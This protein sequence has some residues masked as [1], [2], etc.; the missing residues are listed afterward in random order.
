MKELERER[1]KVKVKEH[2]TVLLKVT[3][4][5]ISKIRDKTP[6]EGVALSGH[7]RAQVLGYQGSIF[8]NV[9]NPSSFSVPL[10]QN[11]NKTITNS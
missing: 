6:G 5:L 3:V 11:K 1:V 9:H 8:N 2:S 7:A 10:K 4:S